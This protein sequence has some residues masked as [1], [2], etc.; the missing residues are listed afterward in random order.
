[1]CHRIRWNKENRWVIESDDFLNRIITSSI[2]NEWSAQNE[3]SRLCE[4]TSILFPHT[5]FHHFSSSRKCVG[6]TEELSCIS[7]RIEHIFFIRSYDHTLITDQGKSRKRADRSRQYR[8]RTRS[9]R[10]WRS[11]TFSGC[12]IY[13][14]KCQKNRDERTER[15][16]WFHARNYGDIYM[17][18]WW[19]C[20]KREWKIR[21]R[22]YFYTRT[23]YR[24][25]N[26][27]QL[28]S[29]EETNILSKRE[30][31]FVKL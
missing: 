26:Y 8:T 20:K 21:N 1:M 22:K 27:E 25:A 14:G 2:C 12:S 13:G 11:N 4:G 5:H 28:P 18:K 23:Y 19:F 16:E 10:E 15:E 24:I 6:R 9:Y 29:Y 3:A 30:S 7:G 17:Q 31:V